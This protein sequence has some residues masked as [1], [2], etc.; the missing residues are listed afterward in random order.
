M[1]TELFI[2]HADRLVKLFKRI[3]ELRQLCDQ[4]VLA[5]QRREGTTE[6]LASMQEALN[7]AWNDYIAAARSYKHHLADNGPAGADNK[8]H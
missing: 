3:D 7:E 2:E 8:P 1:K 6:E 4:Q 5:I